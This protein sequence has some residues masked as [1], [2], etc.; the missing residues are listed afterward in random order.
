[1][2]SLQNVTFDR[3]VVTLGEDSDKFW[4]DKLLTK[5]VCVCVNLGVFLAVYVVM[6]VGRSVC[7]SVRLSVRLFT[8]SFKKFA[9]LLN[10][11]DNTM[12]FIVVYYDISLA[13]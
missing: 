10:G 2:L 4:K 12:M 7:P 3:L 8:T 9:E 11:I 5:L 6:S 1:M 13:V